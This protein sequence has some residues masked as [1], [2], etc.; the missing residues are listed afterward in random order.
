MGN[1]VIRFDIGCRD[2]KATTAFYEKVFGWSGREAGFNTEID[3]GGGKGIDGAVTALGHEPHNYVMIYME[4]ADIDAACT[5]IKDAGGKI[6]I[7]PVEIPEDN[8]P[9]D[10]G[11]FA[12]FNDPEGNLLGIFEP[13]AQ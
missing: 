13:P 8:G 6:T 12:W 7:G 11:K 10:G 1:P 5:A 9:G 2:R 4:V 3:T